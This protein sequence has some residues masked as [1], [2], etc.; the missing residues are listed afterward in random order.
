MHCVC[1]FIDTYYLHFEKNK[2]MVVSAILDTMKTFLNT[3]TRS[4]KS[5][6]GKSDIKKSNDNENKIIRLINDAL[7]DNERRSLARRSESDYNK[8][9]SK[10]PPASISWNNWIT[11]KRNYD[12]TVSTLSDYRKKLRNA[13]RS[14]NTLN[15]KKYIKLIA[16][17]TTTKRRRAVIMNT[18]WDTFINKATQLAEKSVIIYSD[19]IQLQN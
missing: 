2:I 8:W 9:T 1:N 12:S 14:Q 15:I 19:M 4:S 18:K 13:R 11:A 10:I 3:M 5:F 6:A 7:E 16:R 17:A